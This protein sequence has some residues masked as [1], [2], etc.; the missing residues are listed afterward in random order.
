MNTN[1]QVRLFVVGGF[2]GSGKTTAL[3][4]LADR[5]TQQELRVAMITNDQT[6][7]LVDSEIVR[8]SGIHY[9]EISGACFCTRFRDF[10]QTADTIFQEIRPHVILA[11]PVGS[12]ADLIAT[13]IEPLRVY[14]RERYA[15]M[16][17]TVLVDPTRIEEMFAELSGMDSNSQ[18][19]DDIRYLY[20]RQIREADYLLLT[21]ADVISERDMQ[22][23]VHFLRRQYETYNPQLRI[24]PFSAVTRQGMEEW[25]KGLEEYDDRRDRESL[26][27]DRDRHARAESA[28]GWLNLEAVITVPNRTEMEIDAI[29]LVQGFLQRLKNRIQSAPVGHL[30]IFLETQSDAIKASIVDWR[31]GYDLEKIDPGKKVGDRS[32]QLNHSRVLINLRALREPTELVQHSIEAL[33]EAAAIQQAE[34]RLVK[35][36]A[37]RPGKPKPTY[38]IGTM[39]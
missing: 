38:R 32:T 6:E 18:W 5:F 12:A 14:A 19:P 30:K 39:P 10:L 8:T 34:V 1:S 15:V 37:L 27:F 22:R 13:V 17:L 21:K 2:L 29:A 25:L 4:A 31:L 36:K 35:E 16:P 3:T 26:L 33:R 23:A 7:G 28:L 9:R 20:E 11:E 24:Q